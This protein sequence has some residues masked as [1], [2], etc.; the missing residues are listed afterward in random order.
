MPKRVSQ[1]FIRCKSTRTHQWFLTDVKRA[2]SFG[3]PVW[4]M[5]ELCTTVR[6]RIINQHG[7]VAATWYEHPE[8]Y[9]GLAFTAAEY[10]LQEIRE[11]RSAARR[12]KESMNT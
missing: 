12:A 9:K 11:F 2:S 10:R 6:K 8:G 1:E 5:C 4:H 7:E 3:T